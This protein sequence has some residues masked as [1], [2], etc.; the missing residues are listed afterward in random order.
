MLCA[1]VY[2]DTLMGLRARC[3]GRAALTA[4]LLLYPAASGVAFRLLSCSSAAITR[5][6][7]SL[8]DGG[9]PFPPAQARSLV[10]VSVWSSDPHYVCWAGSHRLAALLALAAI[11]AYV[12]LLPVLALVWL[13][14]DSR[15]RVGPSKNA[16]AVSDVAARYAEETGVVS[17]GSAKLILAEEA[18]ALLS[19]FLSDKG[20]FSALW[21][22][23]VV[24]IAAACALSA[25]E[26]RQG[27]S[28][29]A[30]HLPCS[31]QLL[32]VSMQAFLPR[33]A[34]VSEVRHFCT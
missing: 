6:A 14:R 7:L 32:R 25:I 22:A 28:F 18:D 2:A 17:G 19:P 9:V 1:W 34:R 3:C 10:T 24:D 26:V 29:F 33:P 20:Y 21:W 30:S 11:A 31:C 15:H 13:W 4:S 23:S 27:H 12:A 16:G 8:L 5:V